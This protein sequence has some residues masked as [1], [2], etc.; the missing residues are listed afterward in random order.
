[1]QIAVCSFIVFEIKFSEGDSEFIMVVVEDISVVVDIDVVED[2]FDEA[3]SDV[4]VEILVVEGIVVVEV[5]GL[6]VM[7]VVVEVDVVVDVVAVKLQVT[8][9]GQLHEIVLV[10]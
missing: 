3:V 10:S 6:L 4:L 1:M 9:F 2:V 8:M 7:T 5:I